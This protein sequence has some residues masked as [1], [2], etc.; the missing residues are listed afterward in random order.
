MTTDAYRLFHEARIIAV[1]E[2]WFKMIR[3][4]QDDPDMPMT[5]TPE[6]QEMMEDVAAQAVDR[7]R[8]SFN[9]AELAWVRREIARM[10]A[11]VVGAVPQSD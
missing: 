10:A 1:L 3:S 2:R 8:S 6:G 7:H 4:N 9:V 11:G 5:L